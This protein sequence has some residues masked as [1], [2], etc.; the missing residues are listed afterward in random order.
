MR[1]LAAEYGVLVLAGLVIG[2]VPALVAIQ[3][4][5]RALRSGMPWPAMAG[6]LAVFLG[7]AALCVASAAWVASRRYGPEVLKEEV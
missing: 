1:L 6:I 7:S 4:A 3:P 2:I 5:A